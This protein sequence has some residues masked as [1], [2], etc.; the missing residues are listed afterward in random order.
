M[1]EFNIKQQNR[2]RFKASKGKKQAAKFK[3][4]E[5]LARNVFDRQSNASE[6][7]ESVEMSIEKKSKSRRERRKNREQKSNQDNADSN[8]SDNVA[9][10]ELDDPSPCS[11]QNSQQTTFTTAGLSQSDMKT[12]QGFFSQPSTSKSI[13][14]D[15]SNKY[16][17]S[18]DKSSKQSW[19]SECRPIQPENRNGSK[20]SMSQQTF[21][22]FR[23][24][25]SKVD[26]SNDEFGDSKKYRKRAIKSHSD[27]NYDLPTYEDKLEGDDFDDLSETTFSVSSHF[28]M[29]EQKEWLEQSESCTNPFALNLKC[30]A[31]ALHTIPFHLRQS[32]PP[33]T[34]TSDEVTRMI[35]EADSKIQIY[36]DVCQEAEEERKI[37]VFREGDD[38]VLKE[39]FI[40]DFLT[41]SDSFSA[42]KQVA[43]NSPKIDAPASGYTLNF[44]LDEDL[45][46]SPFSTF[47]TVSQDESK[48][49]KKN[50]KSKHSKKSSNQDKVMTG[51][52]LKDERGEDVPKWRK[53]LEMNSDVNYLLNSSSEDEF[54]KQ[55]ELNSKLKSNASSSPSTKVTSSGSGKM[56]KKQNNDKL[57][58]SSKK[59]KGNKKLNCT[60]TKLNEN[61]SKLDSSIASSPSSAPKTTDGKFAEGVLSSQDAVSDLSKS[62][63][64]RKTRV[65][66]TS[67]FNITESLSGL[68]AEKS[69]PIPC[70][71][72]IKQPS[73]S[74]SSGNYQSPSST[75]LDALESDFKRLNFG[76]PNNFKFDFKMSGSTS[77]SK[78]GNSV[79]TK[80]F[81]TSPF[82]QTSADTRTIT[83]SPFRFPS[84][85]NDTFKTQPFTPSPPATKNKSPLQTSPF[86]CKFDFREEDEPKVEK[87]NES[88]KNAHQVEEISSSIPSLVITPTNKTATPAI[89]IVNKNPK[90]KAV[91]EEGASSVASESSATSISKPIIGDDDDDNDIDILLGITKQTPQNKDSST[92]KQAA[93]VKLQSERKGNPQD[94]TATSRTSTSMLDENLDDWLDSVLQS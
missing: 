64:E 84:K 93:N 68:L 25:R 13:D 89:D 57:N 76:S 88:P 33:N 43:E 23:Q 20:D 26:F 19:R 92:I 30:L 53:M 18:K 21:Q 60:L 74:E 24:D 11:S 63:S 71:N 31:A 79:E 7:S 83:T 37:G 16:D 91:S 90:S 6:S 27:R 50:R 59:V 9:N 62:P 54:T 42:D 4:S 73:S 47:T 14:S 87:R 51:N 35:S 46:E 45:L 61:Q 55:P 94:T 39:D 1:S 32:L 78:P 36:R 40:R 67:A 85:P 82:K 69:A 72:T 75:K 34:L 15:L 58:S 48:S 49:K 8:E 81:S 10:R 77:P 52:S 66:G 28:L 86:T 38:N 44:E 29:K 5:K 12:V 65:R 2:D 3:H 17:C 41:C 80:T 22:P 56:S 70:N